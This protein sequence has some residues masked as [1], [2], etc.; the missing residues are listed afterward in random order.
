MTSKKFLYKGEEKIEDT[1]QAM[2]Q[3]YHDFKAVQGDKVY[4]SQKP[5]PTV[6]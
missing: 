2:W 1:T 3:T 6:V 4:T 5:M